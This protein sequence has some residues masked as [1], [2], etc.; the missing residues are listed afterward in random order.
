MVTEDNSVFYSNYYDNVTADN[1]IPPLPPKLF[2]LSESPVP[3]LQELDPS[4]PPVPPK[5]AS[6]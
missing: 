1:E 5:L 3:P 2:D 4:A 6:T